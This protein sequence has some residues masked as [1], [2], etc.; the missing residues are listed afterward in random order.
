MSEQAKVTE[1]PERI[2][3]EDSNERYRR[4]KAERKAARREAVKTSGTLY[5]NLGEAFRFDNGQGEALVPTGGFIRLTGK[6]RDVLV[7]HGHKLEGTT[8][9]QAKANLERAIRNAGFDPTDVLAGKVDTP[10]ESGKEI[11]ND[12]RS[13]AEAALHE[14]DYN[15]A[16]SVLGEAGVELDSRKKPQVMNKLVEIF[17]L[18]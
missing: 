12:L 3:I 11:A 10:S 15:A 18:G 4:E 2:I 16:V 6:D 7:K 1:S 13:R 9:E 17:N 8:P 14:D 5:V